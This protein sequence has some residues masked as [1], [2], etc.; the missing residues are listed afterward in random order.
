M[1]FQKLFYFKTVA[2]TLSF[3]KAAEKI[4]VSQPNISEQISKI[5]EE[6]GCRLFERDRK[7]VALTAE[8]EKFYEFCCKTLENYNDI[9]NSLSHKAK[10]IK[11]GI[12]HNKH[13]LDWVARLEKYNSEQNSVKYDYSLI[14]DMD[15]NSRF[16]SDSYDISFGIGNSEYKSYGHE[17]YKCFT[18]PVCLYAAA[19]VPESEFGECTVLF[20][21][22]GSRGKEETAKMFAKLG[23]NLRLEE[24]PSYD[25]IFIEL[26]KPRTLAL[27][28][29]GLM[30]AG[31]LCRVSEPL[32]CM[33]MGWYCKKLTPE[34][35][36]IIDNLK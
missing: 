5:E 6:M 14:H 11:V 4:Y 26:K 25:E 29:E 8:G 31:E 12:V 10:H 15:F 2:E 18:V 34:A 24:K 35:R 9:K 19:P 30:H 16:G 17:F 21:R 22:F 33:E 28:Y 27:L 36:W 20:H 7:S 23:M 32:V 13:F 3:T 1:D